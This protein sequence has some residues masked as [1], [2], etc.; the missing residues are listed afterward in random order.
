MLNA[1]GGARGC[2]CGFVVSNRGMGL[3]RV[4]YSS[5][6]GEWTLLTR[7]GDYNRWTVPGQMKFPAYF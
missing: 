5:G 7:D 2:C 4:C 3:K 1:F 6:G